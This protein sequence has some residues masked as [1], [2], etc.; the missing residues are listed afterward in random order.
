MRAFGNPDSHKA[1]SPRLMGM[2]GAIASEHYLSAQAGM[3]ALKEGGNA[4]DAACAATLV[5]SVVNP[6]M[7]SLGGECP[8]LL[9][10]AGEDAIVSL[11]GNTRAPRAASLEAFAARGVTAIPPRGVLAAG[12]PAV[13]SALCD[14]QQAYGSMH[15]SRVLAPALDLASRGFPVHEGLVSMPGF[16][17]RDNRQRFLNEWKNSAA[18][19]LHQD[20]SL[21]Q[22]GETLRNPGLADLLQALASAAEAAS[23]PAAS[24]AL[25]R[26]HF[27]EAAPAGAIA[28]FSRAHDG[29]L[30]E[31][32]MR[33]LSTPFETPLHIEFHGGRIAKCG[34]W[35]QGP[36][37]LQL[38]R[39]LQG[40]DLAALGH[41]SSEYLH[42]WVEAAKLAYADREQHY[43]DPA[44]GGATDEL[45]QALISE[46]YAEL[47]RGLLDPARASGEHRPG[48]PLGM[49][50]LL[51]PERVFMPREWGPG[52]VH[53]AVADAMGNLAALTPSGGWISGNDLVP[54]LG[55][56]LT[57]RLQSFVLTPGHPNALAPGKRPR[58]TLSP[59]MAVLPPVAGRPACRMAFGTMG[60][61]QQDQW[62]SQFLLNVLVFGM[63]PV[64][65]IHA[66]KVTCDHFPATFH[67]QAA[68]PRQLRLESRIGEDVV[69]RLRELG[70]DCK[71]E[72]PWSMGYICAAAR[73][74]T[75][76]L[77]A[78]ADPRGSASE[79]FPATALAW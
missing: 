1:L 31:E 25:A 24:W 34:P 60:G 65:A 9:S 57:S 48:D 64:E 68:H 74:D 51:A 37:F 28:A 70:H 40:Y 41:N 76:M 27:Y 79:V 13:F 29:L 8:M 38:L 5:E 78:A 52:T 59:S 71:L 19:Y 26:E 36:V 45:M 20:G 44:A 63:P 10:P 58:T 15:C 42:L 7:F 33:S 39:L 66:A 16:G 46:G 35:C 53:V 17:L 43:G 73:Y 12:P 75:G 50:P 14:M 4:F 56:P 62:T 21:P 30:D 22:P 72:G 3:D 6:H 67:P 2:R 11:N 47:R 18:V 77:E 23:D 55:F 69:Q 49:R 61:D 54:E 32:D